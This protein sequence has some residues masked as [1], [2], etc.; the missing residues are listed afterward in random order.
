MKWTMRDYADVALEFGA[1]LTVI[2]A[3]AAY[4]MGL[5]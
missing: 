3:V 1:M 5:I 4:A 2:A